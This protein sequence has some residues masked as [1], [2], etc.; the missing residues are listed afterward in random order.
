[1]LAVLTGLGSMTIRELFPLRWGEISLFL[2][3]LSDLQDLTDL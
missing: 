2:I 3:D 1:M